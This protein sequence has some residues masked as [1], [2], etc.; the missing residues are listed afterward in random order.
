MDIFPSTL[1]FFLDFF[2][3]DR[4]FSLCPFLFWSSVF[5]FTVFDYPFDIF[6]LFL[7][8]FQVFQ[9]VFYT[10]TNLKSNGRL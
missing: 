4:Y 3:V 5:R 7:I 6:K 2:F 8:Y 10:D 9:I 1:D